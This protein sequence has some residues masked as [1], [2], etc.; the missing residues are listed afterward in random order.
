MGTGTQRLDAGAQPYVPS[1]R[2]GFTRGSFLK[3]RGSWLENMVVTGSQASPLKQ[4]PFFCEGARVLGIPQMRQ[5]L[6]SAFYVELLFHGDGNSVVPGWKGRWRHQKP[7][8]F[9]QPWLQWS[10]GPGARKWRRRVW[11]LMETG[12]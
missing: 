6:E 11:I 4:S 10:L 3:E 2:C 1:L 12:E 7:N 9:N 5:E 8:S